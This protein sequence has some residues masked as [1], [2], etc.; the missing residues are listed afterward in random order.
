M[1]LIRA[2]LVPIEIWNDWA[3]ALG[4]W[5]ALLALGLMVAVILAQVWF[6]YVLNNA[7][8]WPDEAARF[9]MLWMTG[10]AAPSGLRR[11]GFV[12]IDMLSEALPRR[13]AD[14]LILVLLFIAMIV[15]VMGVQLGWTHVNSGW[16]FASSSLRLPLDLVGGAS[17]KIKLAWMYMS[18]F[19]GMVLL[20]IV[21]IELILRR[22]LIIG[23]R[24]EGLKPLSPVELAEAE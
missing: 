1:G 11:G 10:L 4:R 7:L 19:V 22:I 6:R 15:L 9:L 23:G 5:L 12:A 16:L 14:I 24:A 21:N 3:L 17:V 18:V 8:P 13:L 2:M 20:S